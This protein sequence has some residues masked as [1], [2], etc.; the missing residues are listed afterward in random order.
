[1]S[2][3]KKIYTYV[4]LINSITKRQFDRTCLN[5]FKV[6]HEYKLWLF[7]GS[8]QYISEISR[9]WFARNITGVCVIYQG[10][11][12]VITAQNGVDSPR[13]YPTSSNNYYIS[14]GFE[15]DT[16][17]YLD[18]YKSRNPLNYHEISATTLKPFAV[19]PGT[20][21]LLKS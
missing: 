12:A 13:T 16:F 10:V 9:T 18:K 3:N 11:R 21:L 15:A 8:L 4:K 6:K 7:R 14:Y 17:F 2:K 19:K 5:C 20:K 1:M